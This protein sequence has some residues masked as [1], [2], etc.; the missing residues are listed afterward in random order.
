[1]ICPEG[2][3][4]VA[5]EMTCAY[6]GEGVLV[7]SNEFSGQKNVEAMKKIT[8]YLEKKEWVKKQLISS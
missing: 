1:M 3:K 2:K 8:E 4:L 5:E 6:T 7:N